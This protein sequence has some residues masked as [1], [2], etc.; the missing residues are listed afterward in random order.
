MR[1][2]I[3]VPLYNKEHYLP[4]LVDSV[5]TQGFDDFELLLVDD[6]STD[7]TAA[8]T[9]KLA[10]ANPHIRSFHKKN[11]G[12]SS[13]R[14]LGLREANGEYLMF[15]DGDDLLAP[16]SLVRVDAAILQ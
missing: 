2:S 13:A 10:A 14:N 1:F 4:Q 5:V 7:G 12:V 8:L 3:I 16:R 11:G 6:G 9:D 15:L